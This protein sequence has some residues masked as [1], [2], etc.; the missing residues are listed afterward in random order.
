MKTVGD[1][2]SM[3]ASLKPSLKDGE[4]IFCTLDSPS[5]IAE[6]KILALSFFQEE[7]AVS[8]ILEI[9]TAKRLGCDTRMPMKRIVLEVFL[10]LMVWGS[11]LQLR[12]RWRKNI[13]LATWW[14]PTITTMSS[15][16]LRKQNRRFQY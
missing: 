16:Q 14:R 2:A 7:E 15:Y 6:A 9:D 1:T 12:L 10:R 11:Q 13:Y 8:F 3:L 5:V 4:F